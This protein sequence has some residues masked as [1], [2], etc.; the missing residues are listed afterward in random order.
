M[1]RLLS[2]VAVVGS[3]LVGCSCSTQEGVGNKYYAI[4]KSN[5]VIDTTEIK[6]FYRN[7]STY[8][9]VKMD[10]TSTFINLD[11]AYVI[12]VSSDTTYY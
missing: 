3:I 7:A 8:H 11:S 9:I 6:N 4:T 5:G 10:G 2:S 1:S 12:E